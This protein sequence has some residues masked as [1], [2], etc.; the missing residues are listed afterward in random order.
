MHGTADQKIY[1]KLLPFMTEFRM[2][3]LRQAWTTE[4]H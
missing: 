4:V 1:K 2:L 3:R